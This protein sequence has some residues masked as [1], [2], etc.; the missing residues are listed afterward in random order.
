MLW[1]MKEAEEA[2][3]ERIRIMKGPKGKSAL[4]KENNAFAKKQV[5]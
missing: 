4:P 2:E 3:A 5:L 1:A